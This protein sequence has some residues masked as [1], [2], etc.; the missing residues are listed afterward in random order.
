[1][2]CKFGRIVEVSF[3]RQ[4]SMN[5]KDFF[6]PGSTTCTGDSTAIIVAIVIVIVIVIVVREIVVA[7]S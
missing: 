2:L 5:F 3:A 4:A 6:T 7:E 1:M